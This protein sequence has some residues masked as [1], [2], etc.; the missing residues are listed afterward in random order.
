MATTN[1]DSAASRAKQSRTPGVPSKEGPR[2]GAKKVVDAREQN[3]NKEEQRETRAKQDK[4]RSDW[5]GMA[6][7]PEQGEDDVA[8][9][10]ELPETD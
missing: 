7:K 9:P 5:E 4:E 8:A 6:P 3:Q 1:E 10:G 2:E